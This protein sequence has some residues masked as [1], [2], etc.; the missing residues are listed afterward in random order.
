MVVFLPTW[1]QSVKY[2]SVYAKLHVMDDD[3]TTY[4]PPLLV[5]L[6]YYLR[7]VAVES[8]ELLNLTAL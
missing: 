7:V 8:F 2:L 4:T 1:T 6:D 5:I 3:D